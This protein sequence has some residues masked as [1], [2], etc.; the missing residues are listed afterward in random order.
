[1]THFCPRHCPARGFTLI[2]LMV[3][4]AIIGILAAVG[5]PSYRDHVLRGYLVD[6][7]S[8]LDSFRAQ[9][10]RHYQDNRTYT[11]VTVGGVTFTSPCL[12]T[13]AGPRTFGKFVVTC[14]TAPT[15]SSYVLQA[16]GS[17]PV[18]GFSYRVD[19]LGVNS[20]AAAPS[21]YGTCATQWIV[22]KGQPC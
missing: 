4:V 19:Q 14:S 21:G 3:T 5:Y 10:E 22:K 8:A 11:T 9:M 13:D 17:G 1:M 7:T 6:G 12:T 16:T 15:A 20:T 18:A 2:E